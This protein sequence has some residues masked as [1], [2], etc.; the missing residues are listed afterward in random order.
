[1]GVFGEGPEPTIN[2]GPSGTTEI[3]KVWDHQ[4]QV[5]VTVTDTDTGE[6]VDK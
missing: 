3:K 4:V 1:M 6:S 5:N 2:D